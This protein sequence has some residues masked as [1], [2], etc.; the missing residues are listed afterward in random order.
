[1]ALKVLIVFLIAD[2]IATNTTP[3]IVRVAELATCI[4]LMHDYYFNIIVLI[5]Q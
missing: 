3:V 2:F 1:M 4:N 5:I